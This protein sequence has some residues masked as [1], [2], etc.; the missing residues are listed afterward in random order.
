MLLWKA[1]FFCRFSS[2]SRGK[3]PFCIL[4]VLDPKLFFPS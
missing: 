2:V 4:L 3:N 1:A